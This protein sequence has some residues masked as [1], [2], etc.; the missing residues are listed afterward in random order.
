MTDRTWQQ[1]VDDLGL[2]APTI[3]RAT[4]VSPASVRAYKMGRHQPTDEW[5]ATVSAL[6]DCI[7]R[8]RERVA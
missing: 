1:R 6:L 5:V 3:A 4:N 7:E 8:A 2:K